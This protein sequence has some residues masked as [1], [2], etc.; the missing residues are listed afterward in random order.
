MFDRN[1]TNYGLFFLKPLNFV[2][3]VSVTS[4]TVI[5]SFVFALLGLGFS[6][7]VVYLAM[8]YHNSLIAGGC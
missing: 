6:S 8:E 4:W 7:D 2:R 1:I 5:W 3:S